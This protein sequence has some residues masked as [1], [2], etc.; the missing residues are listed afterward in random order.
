M[1]DVEHY[2]SV[3]KAEFNRLKAVITI[4]RWQKQKARELLEQGRV[5]E[6]KMLL[7]KTEEE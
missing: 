1:D 3:T 4:L 2:I 7:A 5:D 6:A